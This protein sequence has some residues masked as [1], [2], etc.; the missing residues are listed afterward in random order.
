MPTLDALRSCLVETAPRLDRALA[1]AGREC[2]AEL[3]ARPNG[4]YDLRRATAESYGLSQGA[5]L[6][7]DRPSTGLSY[8]LWYHARRVNTCLRQVLPAVAG[9]RPGSLVVHD[10]GA[11]TGAFLWAFALSAYAARACGGTPP[12]VHVVNVDSSPVMLDYLARA[13]RHLVSVFPEAGEGVTWERAVNAWTR[14][15]ASAAEGWLCASYLFDHSDKAD[16]LS[17]DFAQLLGGYEPSRVL[18]ST[19]SRKGAESF[20]EI[21]R[22]MAGR[23]YLRVDASGASVFSGQLRRVSEVRAGLTRLDARIRPRAYWDDPWYA[24]ATFVPATPLLAIERSEGE[25]VRLFMPKLPRRPEAVLTPEQE[26]AAALSDGPTLLYG[27]A[28]SGKSVVLTERLRLLAE[29]HGY[30]HDLRVLVTTFNKELVYVLKRW[31]SQLLDSGRYTVKAG[32]RSGATYEYRFRDETGALSP[33]PSLSLMHFDVLPT[34]VGGV[35]REEGRGDYTVVDG[36]GAGYEDAVRALIEEAIE[37]VRARLPELGVSPSQV[38]EDRVF[39]PEAVSDEFHR[40]VYGR[41]ATTADAY[42]QAERGWRPA[43]QKGGTTRRLMWEVLDAFREI[44]QERRL[45]TFL[46]RR[47]HLLERLEAGELGAPFTHVLVDEVQDCTPADFRVFRA[48]LENPQNLFMTGDLAQSVHLGGSARRDS[49]AGYPE[50]EGVRSRTLA[51][52]F[53]L[54]F[55]ISEALVPL[56]GEI[57]TKRSRSKDSGD[58]TLLHPYKGS[59]PGVR[60]IVLAAE[61]AEAMAAKLLSVGEAY[62]ATLGEVGFAMGPGPLVLERDQALKAAVQAQGGRAW[63][64]TILRLKG[65]EHP[66]VVWSTRTEVPA[67]DD[68][69][70]YVYT[71]LT[72]GS[73]VVVV[74]LFPEPC[75]AYRRVLRTFEPGSVLVWDAESEAAFETARERLEAEEPAPDGDE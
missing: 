5:D 41:S 49:T 61:T 4:V 34:R 12:A 23:G 10:L 24:E 50:L 75:A 46:H 73:G 19:S 54:P 32:G 69:E 53:R 18:L 47:I 16:D 58:V 39:D 29:A 52:S 59:P 28:G 43:I 3:L 51:G 26:K 57:Q 7:Y 14:S 38:R 55:R 33:H 37:R 62:G 2:A 74:A 22:A 31:T 66:W 68:A 64:D 67:E 56:S 27:A 72:R 36:G 42:L 11:G 40:V 21:T 60:P 9:A 44:C 13:W 48:L 25:T 1:D 65:L 6:C 70:E 63:T 45:R 8:G 15:E 17:R 30:G 71:I 35:D 20:G